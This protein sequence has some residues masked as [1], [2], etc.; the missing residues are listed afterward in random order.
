MRCFLY[1][2]GI[3]QGWFVLEYHWAA[4]HRDSVT[5]SH[6]TH[7]LWTDFHVWYSIYQHVYCAEQST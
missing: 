7:C 2:I 5:V 4:C 6:S 3:G 1:T